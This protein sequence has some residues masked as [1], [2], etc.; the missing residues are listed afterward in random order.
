MD[1]LAEASINWALD[2]IRAFGDTDLFPPPFEFEAIQGQWQVVLEH[3]RLVD[4]HEYEVRPA[5][6]M[7]VPKNPIGFRPSAQLD[8]LDSLVYAATRNHDWHWS[9]PTVLVHTWE[10]ERLYWVQEWLVL[11]TRNTGRPGGDLAHTVARSY[12]LY[13]YLVRGRG[14][15][16]NSHDEYWILVYEGEYPEWE[17]MHES[18]RVMGFQVI[19][20]LDPP[21]EQLPRDLVGLQS[22]TPPQP[23]CPKNPP[24]RRVPIPSP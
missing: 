19:G 16:Q 11:D 7:A 5:L 12:L 2:H 24:R 8:P 21:E 13:G 9:S 23:V 15:V 20:H 22:S 18:F 4:L 1:T 3:L 6:R 14:Q 17:A 10:R